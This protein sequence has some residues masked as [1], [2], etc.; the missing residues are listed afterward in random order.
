MKTATK[1]D[2]QNGVV[3]NTYYGNL[4]STSKKCAQGIGLGFLKLKHVIN[5]KCKT[6]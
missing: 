4:P 1:E 6:Y 5:D 2:F 3:A